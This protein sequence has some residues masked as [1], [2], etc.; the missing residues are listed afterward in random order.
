MIFKDEMSE[1]KPR[2]CHSI[3][4]AAAYQINVAV[5]FFFGLITLIV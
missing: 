2:M 1:C 5:S 3:W 4:L